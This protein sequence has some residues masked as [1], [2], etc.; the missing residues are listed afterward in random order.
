VGG[1]DDRGSEAVERCEQTHQPVG[2][3]G[4][5]VS[6]RLVGHEQFGSIDHRACDR[7]ALLFTA[8]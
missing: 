7:H 6:R 2:H 3:L 8:R 4:I 5:H 1:D